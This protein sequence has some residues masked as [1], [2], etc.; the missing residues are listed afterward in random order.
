MK[1]PLILGWHQESVKLYN[2]IKE[3]PALGYNIQGFITLNQY[4]DA[5]H[6]KNVPLLGDLSRLEAL[7]EDL[8]INEIL[9]A[10]QR[11]E[12]SKLHQILAICEHTNTHYRIVSEVY[13]AVFT[14]VTREV[15][16]DIFK[17]TDMGRRR[18]LDLMGSLILIILF[19]PFFLLVAIWIKFQ[20]KGSIFISQLRVGQNG[21][22]FRLFKFRCNKKESQ[23]LDELNWSIDANSGMTGIGTFLRKTQIEDLPQLL[24][25]FKGDMSFIGPKPESPLFVDIIKQQIPLYTNRLRIKPGITGWA[26]INWD[27]EETIE[28]VREKLKYDLFYLNKRTLKLDFKILFSTL[29]TLLFGKEY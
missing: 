29:S 23:E 19:F 3:F 24:N 27:H 25:V 28:D 6:H 10:I 8:N 12:Q 16:T 1:N 7:I 9:I 22:L 20:S 14:N 5:A 13:D 21:Q 18:S 4:E 2:K 17:Q 11:K 15:F 26:Q